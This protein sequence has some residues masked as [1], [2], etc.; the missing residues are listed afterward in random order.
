MVK[1]D[2]LHAL[3]LHTY[4]HAGEWL[5]AH[6]DEVAPQVAAQQARDAAAGIVAA[7]ARGDEVE[8]AVRGVLEALRY[9]RDN[10]LTRAIRAALWS[11]RAST[12]EFFDD[13]ARSCVRW[14][15][16]GARV[17][18]FSSLPMAAQQALVR[19]GR[20]APAV[21]SFAAWFD[22]TLG[23]RDAVESYRAIAA[24]MATTPEKTKVAVDNVDHGHAAANAGCQVLMVERMGVMG[25]PWHGFRT[26]AT[27][28]AL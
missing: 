11:E 13:V 18:T 17:V 1:P 12:V 23:E 28:H 3:S 14:A 8:A 5:R 7:P 2:A 20:G 27:V 24:A 16:A 19:H 22:A 4:H 26:E 25:T 10:P 6:F 21:E 15:K 9:D